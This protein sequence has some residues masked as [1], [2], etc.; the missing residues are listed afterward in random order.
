MI[1]KSW[2]IRNQVNHASSLLE[3]LFLWGVGTFSLFFT[4]AFCL[5]L[6]Q[7]DFLL[8]LKQLRAEKQPTGMFTVDNGHLPVF[9]YSF[10]PF[11]S[12]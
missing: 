1:L 3:L 8:A 6:V 2:S 9:T 5:T 11:I 7:G 4:E 12:L 10:A